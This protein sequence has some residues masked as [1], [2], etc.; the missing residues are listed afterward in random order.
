MWI[1][2]GALI[3]H[4]CYSV[5][6]LLLR[7]KTPN[8]WLILLFIAIC[9]PPAGGLLVNHFRFPGIPLI[10]NPSWVVVT[11]PLLFLYCKSIVDP[12]SASL[13]KNWGHLLPFLVLNVLFSFNI[14]PPPSP[15][16][17]LSPG[18]LPGPVPPPHPGSLNPHVI[19][20]SFLV[21]AFGT[22]IAYTVLTYR[23]I[24]AQK[25]HLL[26]Y[27]SYTSAKTTLKWITGL[28]WAF[29]ALFIVA[30]FVEKVILLPVY[31]A[32]MAFL[33]SGF[34]LVFSYVLSA[35]SLKQPVLYQSGHDEGA[36]VH[37]DRKPTYERTGL[38]SSDKDRYLAQLER[39]MA[40]KRPYLDA[41]LRI[42]DLSAQCEIPV[43][44]L[45]QLVNESFGKNFFQFI[46]DYRVRHACELL[47][48][49]DY[50]HWNMLAI[51]YEAGFNSKSSFNAIFK[52]LMGETPSAF[53][54]RHTQ[55]SA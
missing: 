43:H 18:S 3:L 17:G 11:G 52:D 2:V 35:F 51:G 30:N 49:D 6:Y 1:L 34:A 26:N 13:H 20:I 9:L 41:G 44:H 5:I 16:P 31:G 38:K 54:K 53:Q 22:F 14:V 36:I 15:P 32:R 4:T 27:Y 50:R 48:K 12:G 23:L 55:A 24:R 33:H 46:N 7:E 45:S 29:S 10:T 47:K 8:A 25:P 19:G 28:L 21:A 37:N 40:E 39:C 42:T